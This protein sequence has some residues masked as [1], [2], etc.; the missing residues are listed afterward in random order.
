MINDDW[1][2]KACKLLWLPATFVVVGGVVLTVE[3]AISGEWGQRLVVGLILG[4][5][6]WILGWVGWRVAE[7]LGWFD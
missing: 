1:A 6:V 3:L 4:A 2:R 5:W 7:Y